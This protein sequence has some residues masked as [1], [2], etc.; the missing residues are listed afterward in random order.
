MSSIGD[1]LVVGSS[2]GSVET[3]ARLVGRLDLEFQELTQML[4][5]P[6]PARITTAVKT[7]IGTLTRT[8]MGYEKEVAQQKLEIQNLKEFA[9]KEM[10]HLMNEV[11]RW[12]DSHFAL[13]TELDRK[14]ET[15][16]TQLTQL[17]V[18]KGQ[19]AEFAKG[20][21][22][23]PMKMYVSPVKMAPGQSSLLQGF[24]NQAQQPVQ[25]V[26]AAAP[27]PVRPVVNPRGR[28]R[29]QPHP[30]RKD[31][32]GNATASSGRAPYPWARTYLKTRAPVICAVVRPGH[33]TWP[34][35]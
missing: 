33:R 28:K 7:L 22:Q 11:S 4:G 16:K 5:S 15:I 1:Y 17:K 18:Y 24:A 3:F 25:L 32:A 6:A 35:R 26:P 21:S 31:P 2:A 20:G 13:K 23:N 9:K 12:T 29:K 30:V 10:K 19:W 34:R 14:R 27:A 8:M